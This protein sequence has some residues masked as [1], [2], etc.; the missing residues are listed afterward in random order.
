VLDPDYNR[1]MDIQQAINLGIYRKFQEQGVAFAYPTYTVNFSDSDRVQE[2]TAERLV[3]AGRTSM[4]R[5]FQE[6]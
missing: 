2:R 6:G 1:Y 5:I 3:S 4:R